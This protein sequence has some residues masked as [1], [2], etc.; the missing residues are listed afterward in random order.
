LAI[1]FDFE[2]MATKDSDIKMQGQNFFKKPD[3][4]IPAHAR[5]PA[6]GSQQSCG[7]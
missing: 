2:E 7:L 6:H 4:I 5:G 1:E 3:Q